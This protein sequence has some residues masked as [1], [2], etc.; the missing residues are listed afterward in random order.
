[1]KLA[2]T[3]QLMRVNRTSLPV[4]C[5]YEAGCQDN[6]SSKSNAAIGNCELPS[7]PEQTK[8]EEFQINHYYQFNM[9]NPTEFEVESTSTDEKPDDSEND[10]DIAKETRKAI[11]SSK[12]LFFGALVFVLA[13]F[14]IGTLAR[15]SCGG[16][17]AVK[18]VPPE[19]QLNSN[20]CIQAE[21]PPQPKQ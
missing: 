5:D 4:D 14:S 21:E 19:L 3:L 8:I 13:I 11:V 17:L 18:L 15:S 7:S 9:K 2:L 10:E 1:M 16:S 20:N 12:S 6:S